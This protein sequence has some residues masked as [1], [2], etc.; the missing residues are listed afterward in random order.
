M[1][2]A[3]GQNKIR[4][5]ASHAR[6]LRQTSPPL[7][8]PNRS[9]STKLDA[10]IVPAS[11]PASSFAGLID[12][13]VHIGTLLVVL[14]SRQTKIDQV[15]ERVAR[16]PGAQALIIDV[17]ASYELPHQPKRT[18]ADRFMA[19]SSDRVS[20]L[21]VKR[22]LGLLLARLSGWTKILFLDDDITLS[23]TESFTRLASQLDDN[24]IAG[25]VC[26][27]FPDNSVVCHARR[28]AKLRQDNFVS[29]SVLGVNCTDLPLPFFPDV[30]NEDWFFF[31]KA[32]ARRELAN[33][34]NATQSPYEPF[35]DPNR[36]RHEEFGDLLAEGLYSLIGDTDDP[37]MRYHQLL[38]GATWQFWS[39]FIYARRASMHATRDRLEGFGFG[40][41]NSD[42]Q[43][44]QALRS[45]EAAELQ[46]DSIKPDL[47]VDFL[48]MWQE[49]LG[50]WEAFYER[51][52]NVGNIR[53]AMDFL[54]IQKWRRAQFGGFPVSGTTVAGRS[55]EFDQTLSSSAIAKTSRRS[56]RPVSSGRRW[57]SPVV[58]NPS[59]S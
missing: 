37:S 53:E 13:S 19:A 4:Q 54:Q 34:G 56:N 20:D 30:Y 42:D 36:A 21:S 35:T 28:L 12:L 55:V 6:L 27:E 51:I 40:D 2:Q 58:S 29:G 17:S 26:R 16:T 38:N 44:G 31:S 59:S 10:L 32:V 7:L 3:I 14:C 24:Q 50:E 5:K 1:R 39:D 9:R 41:I 33:V 23:R 25:M 18:S 15:A 22:N 8:L 45:L 57:R 43:T 49:D 11:R 47:C 46:L 52:S 48:E